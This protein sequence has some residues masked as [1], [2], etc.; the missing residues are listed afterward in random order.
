MKNIFILALVA[1]VTL[2]SCQSPLDSTVATKNNNSTQEQTQVLGGKVLVGMKV[3][4]NSN[5]EN[6]SRSVIESKDHNKT[7]S[8]LSSNISR[9]IH[10]KREEIT[11]LEVK[12]SNWNGDFIQSYLFQKSEPEQ[13]VHFYVQAD[14]YYAFEIKYS[15]GEVEAC[16]VTF[17]MGY[18]TT[19]VVDP[20]AGAVQV[21]WSDIPNLIERIKYYRDENAVK[22]LLKEPVNNFSLQA[23]RLDNKILSSQVIGNDLNT[24]YNVTASY[25]GDKGVVLYFN[26]NILANGGRT[27]TVSYGGILTN[28]DGRPFPDIGYNVDVDNTVIEEGD[29]VKSFGNSDV[30]LVKD[31]RK[32][33]FSSLQVYLDM[34]F[35]KN[36]ST[37]KSVIQENID[38]IP[39]GEILY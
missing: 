14:K 24:V 30:Y 2:V 18:K 27:I 8:L 35:P 7:F 16:G 10:I 33:K 1:M 39:D 20:V 32:C 17:G 36:Y 6:T 3:N 4:W 11:S 22:I 28:A 31:G 34:G 21:D 15:T 13:E 5:S 19:L 29:L 25:D 12:M 37:I 26:D 23:F 38:S 9:G